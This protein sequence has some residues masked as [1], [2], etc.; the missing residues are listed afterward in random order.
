MFC[1]KCATQ[2]IDGA[3]FCRAC[4]ANISLVPQA[5]TGQL[6]EAKSADYSDRFSRRRRKR[7]EPTLDQGIRSLMMGIGF[8]VVSVMVDL[9]SPAGWTWWYWLLIPAFAMLG[10]GVSE[11]VRAKQA[12]G[13]IKTAQVQPSQLGGGNFGPTLP[14]RRTAELRP[15]I[16]SVTE[17]TTRH[18][19]AEAP[20]RHFD[21]ATGEEKLP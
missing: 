8:I 6:T 3:S 9:Y 21:A 17:G 11:I 15:P 4:G 2:N 5:L 16:P 10:R 18:L 19:G 14:D 12:K 7:G 13:E 1:P 20:T